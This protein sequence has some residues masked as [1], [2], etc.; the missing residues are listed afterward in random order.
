MLYVRL[1][2][3]LKCHHKWGCKCCITYGGITCNQTW[4][5]MHYHSSASDHHFHL[6][7]PVDAIPSAYATKLYRVI[8]PT[9]IVGVWV[10]LTVTI[11]R[12]KPSIISLHV[13]VKLLPYG[14]Q[15]KW[16]LEEHYYVRPNP[17]LVLAIRAVWPPYPA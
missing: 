5:L 11:W 9:P 15:M 3:T 8:L 1:R 7:Q 2:V 4:D 14:D 13:H 6:N 16:W 10:N 17:C 12:A